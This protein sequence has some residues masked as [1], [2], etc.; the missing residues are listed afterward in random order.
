[1]VID[2]SPGA[3]SRISSNAFENENTFMNRTEKSLGHAGLVRCCREQ[4][5]SQERR[6]SG[7]FC[8]KSETFQLIQEAGA[9]DRESGQ[10]GYW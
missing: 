9:E 2:G 10:F 3:I 7:E 6:D 4:V 5:Q 8:G 1:M